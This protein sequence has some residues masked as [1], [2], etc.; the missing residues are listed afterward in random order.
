M[1]HMAAHEKLKDSLFVLDKCRLGFILLV[2]MLHKSQ[3]RV[4]AFEFLVATSGFLQFEVGLPPHV[5]KISR[6]CWQATCKVKSHAMST[7]DLPGREAYQ[8]SHQDLSPAAT[9]VAFDPVLPLVRIPVAAGEGDDT[10]KG[11]YVLAFRNEQTWRQSWLNCQDKI[12]SQCEAG[13]KVGCSISAAKACQAPWWMTYFPFLNKG[14]SNF[15]HLA[16]L[17]LKCLHFSLTSPSQLATF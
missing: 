6:H 1:L 5:S 14:C 7:L 10:S 11:P 17:F 15:T 4:Q 2:R 3:D 13:A 8:S 12:A 16:N 9:T